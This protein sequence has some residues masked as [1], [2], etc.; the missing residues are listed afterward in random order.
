MSWDVQHI[1]MTPPIT[2]VTINHVLLSPEFRIIL[3]FLIITILTAVTFYFKIKKFSL[4]YAFKKAVFL[5]FFS[6]G[7]FYAVY[8]DIGWTSWIIT[9]VNKYWG[10]ST[11][12][13]LRRMDDGIYEFSVEAKKILYSDYQLYS[14]NNYIETRM[15]YY[16][17]PFY[18]REQASYIVVIADNDARFDHLSRIFTRGNKTITNVKPVLVFSQ[19]AYILKRQ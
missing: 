12:D 15:Q 2:G 14:S 19:N 4:S 18:R 5:A 11:E 17:L 13:K 7:L 16:L 8:A 1:F 6:S 3:F 9:D 10:L